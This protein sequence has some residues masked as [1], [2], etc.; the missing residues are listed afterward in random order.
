MLKTE[1]IAK[2]LRVS[3]RH[4]RRLVERREIPFYRIGPRSLRFDEKEVLAA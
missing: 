3:S 1:Q 4:I 2:R